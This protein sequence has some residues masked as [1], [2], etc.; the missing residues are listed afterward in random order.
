[1]L[2][3]GK[4][5]SKL[6]HNSPN[7]FKKSTL[8]IVQKERVQH[9]PMENTVFKMNSDLQNFQHVTQL[10]IN[11]INP[12]NLN[13]RDELDDNLIENGHEEFSCTCQRL[14]KCNDYNIEPVYIYYQAREVQINFIW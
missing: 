5:L 12:L 4:E 2:L 14:S 1:M 13:Q 11:T 9:S 3:S 6:P 7:I 10:K 8:N